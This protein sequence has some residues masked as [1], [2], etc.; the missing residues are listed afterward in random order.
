[1]P[2][3]VFP[4]IPATADQ[5][6]EALVQIAKLS[7]VAASATSNGAP[8]V[9]ETQARAFVKSFAKGPLASALFAPKVSTEPNYAKM[10]EYIDTLP[11]EMRAEVLN[12]I[13][14]ES[15]GGGQ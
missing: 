7:P 5:A 11:A 9:D 13:V 6:Y 15:F 14:E 8:S 2:A 1:M 12:R 4:K 3:I 10:A